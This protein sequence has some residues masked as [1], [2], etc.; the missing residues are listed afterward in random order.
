MCRNPDQAG[1]TRKEII[2][3]AAL[4]LLALVVVTLLFQHQARAAARV[5]TVQN[6]RQWGI[7]LNLYLLEN[8]HTLP[9]AGSR[10]DDPAAWFNTL[11]PYLSLPSL[12]DT[13]AAQA[14]PGTLWTDP[15]AALSPSVSASSLVTY[16]MNAWLQPDTAA[17]PWRIYDIEDPSATLFLV[18]TQPGRLRALPADVEFRHNRHAHALF[19]DG[20]VEPIRPLDTVPPATDPQ[21]NPAVRPTWVPFY[22]A[23]APSP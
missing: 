20:H 13:P 8:E 21:A 3:V 11:P 15:S 22:Q 12:S 23:P 5:A 14:G 9:A 17:G 2:V 18:E 10:V 1:L 4:G 16:G 19:C 6:L 7:S